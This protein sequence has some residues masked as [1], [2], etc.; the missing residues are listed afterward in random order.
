MRTPVSTGHA[1]AIIDSSDDAI[2]SKDRDGII[3][4]WN[5]GAERLYGYTAEEAIGE[6]IS[7]IIPPQRAG[8]E[9]RILT[10]ILAGKHVDH[11]ETERRRKDGSIVVI[12]L[13][14]SPIRDGDGEITGAAVIARDIT[15]QRRAAERARR[16]H[17]LTESLSRAISSDRA[18]RI[19]IE[20]AV[21]ALQADAATVALLDRAGEN[22]TLI[23][24]YGYDEE[25]LEAWSTFPVSGDLPMSVA[26]REGRPLWSDSAEDARRRFTDL[27]EAE[28]RFESLAVLPLMVEGRVNGAVAFSFREPREFSPEEQALMFAATQ[29]AANAL[30]RAKLHE[31]E[32]EA[33]Q[34]LA[35]IVR[36][37]EIL[38]ESLELDETLRRLAAVAVP[39]VAD[40]FAVDL[41]S[42]DGM[43]NVVVSHV[44][45]E[46]VDLAR[47]LRE[48][49]PP[50]PEAPTGLW[51]VI[52]TGEPELYPEIPDELLIESA[53]DEEHLRVLRSLG[54]S[55]AMIVPLRA[56]GRNL[57]AVTFVA[58]ESGRT[59]GEDDLSF[60]QELASHAALAI[61]NAS[62]F[63][64]EHEA[65]VTLQ[66]ALLPRRLPTLPGVELATRYLPAGPNVEAGGDWY[67]VIDLGADEAILVIG[68]VSGRGIAAASI[69]GSL[70]TAIQAYAL[71]RLRPADIAERLGRLMVNLVG[72]EMATMFLLRFDIRS[73]RGEYVRVG[74]PPALV[75]H[76]DGFVSELR[77]RG[78][79]PLGIA[80]ELSVVADQVTLPRESTVLL[81]TDGLIER[82]GVPI[83]E[84]VRD[85]KTVLGRAPLD[86][87]ACLDTII[88]ELQPGAGE[89]D[90][91]VLAVRLGSA[92]KGQA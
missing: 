82:R 80:P 13:S 32:R 43:R 59:Y 41:T 40:W 57:G 47:E 19:L 86:V 33:R 81:Y 4:S 51:N 39:Q 34:R 49:Y 64:H 52:R 2:L 22:L 30:E 76:P 1:E 16:L 7:I 18:A 71:D 63:K 36:A 65:A 58:A 92:P 77:G 44:D 62:R 84:G 83:D 85:L 53:R 24:S 61:D 70:R 9:R 6:P 55:S 67:D 88:E 79:P 46:K 42:E 60:A 8:E 50:D 23:A 14:V 87:E 29:Q 37:S 54:F 48:R 69:M 45:P 12:S 20:E 68:D 11:Y 25:R 89:D 73:G 5:R 72:E 35:F 17:G 27:A 75:R 56:Q 21:P 10:R 66:R 38:G 15:A 74:H 28:F 90:V 26:V 3:T 91:A 78:S 31:A